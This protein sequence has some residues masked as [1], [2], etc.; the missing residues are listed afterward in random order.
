MLDQSLLL[1]DLHQLSMLEVYRRH[2]MDVTPVF[3]LFVRKLSFRHGF[4]MM[5]GLEQL[6][7]FLEQM[8]NRRR[9]PRCPMGALSRL[10]S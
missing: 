6:V 3:E 5:V 4:L 9:S 2:S 1:S 10:K 7:Q 8:H